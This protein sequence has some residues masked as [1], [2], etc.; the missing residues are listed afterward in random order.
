MPDQCSSELCADICK[1]VFK[2]VKLKSQESE[3]DKLIAQLKS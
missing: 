2:V 1:P 3:V